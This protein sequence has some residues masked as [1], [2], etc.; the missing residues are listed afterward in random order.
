MSEL[1]AEHPFSLTRGGPF[2]QATRAL[3]ITWPILVAIAW[4]PMMAAALVQ[5]ALGLQVDP[6]VYDPSVHTRALVALPL[7][8][9]AEHL[10]EIRCAHTTE[11]VREQGIVDRGRFDAILDRAERLR[12]SRMVE[13][14]LALIVLGIGEA[15]LWRF[16]DGAGFVYA[17]EH[18]ATTSFASI[19]YVGLALPLFQFLVLRWLWHWG[20]WTYVLARLSRLQIQTNAIHPDRAAGLR[21]LNLPIDAFAVFVASLSAV[22]S[23]VWC[24]KCYEKL[25]TIEK[26]T[27]EFFTFVV[28]AI[29]VACGPLFAFTAKIYNTRHRDLGKY[30]VLARQYATDFRRTWLVEH[31]DRSPLG[32][33]DIQ[34]LNDLGGAYR[35]TEDTRLWPFGARTI[36]AIGLCAIVPM[37]PVLLVSMPLAELLARFGK[38]LVG[39]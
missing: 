37:L 29:V 11:L 6:L 22:L 26:L 5:R 38:T 19:W 35:T 7:L 31:G 34:S 33:S 4:V 15:T 24:L 20:L 9:L 39:I 13:A 30:H 1:R 28:L 18:R 3:H 27:P 2:F 17:I 14:L 8:W 36:I 16:R 23:A 12:D 21:M 25:T 10:L 32:T